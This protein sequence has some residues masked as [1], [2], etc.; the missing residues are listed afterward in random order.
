MEHYDTT[1]A[2]RA[3]AEFVDDLSNWYVRR[4]GGASG[5]AIRRAFGTLR[6]CLV[7]TAKLLAPFTPFVADAIYETST[8]GSVGPSVRLPE[9][10]ERDDTWSGA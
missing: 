5:T 3:I 7:T 9:P 10:G 1:R 6:E 8:A 4:S 2:G